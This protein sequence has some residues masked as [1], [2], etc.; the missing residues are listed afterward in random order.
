MATHEPEGVENLALDLSDEGQYTKAETLSLKDTR[1]DITND[2]FEDLEFD[3]NFV[4]EKIET[5]NKAVA[6]LIADH[7]VTLRQICYV[8]G[9]ILY[10]VFFFGAIYH[11]T[12]S[13][14]SD[15]QW[16]DGVGFLI[17]VTI[18]VYTIMFYFK[19]VKPS[20]SKFLKSKSGAKF[21]DGFVN[22]VQKAQEDLFRTR[23]AAPL[24][25]LGIFSLILI[26]LIIDTQGDRDRLKSF[27]GLIVL[28]LLGFFFS[29]SPG[30]V[31]WR[32]L[33]WGLSLQFIF[34]I[35]IIKWSV[36][37]SIFDCLGNKVS[38]LQGSSE[39]HE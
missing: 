29:K 28:V 8:I 9:F 10:N 36:G 13:D 21:Q 35:F 31:V 5:F 17:I 7:Q 25:Y 30:K 19:I 33:A 18:F 16:C 32:H 6:D 14:K 37:A 26:Y 34:A 4:T 38:K 11:F 20:Y 2:D 24:V 27:F 22:R 39:N 3:T 12:L 1:L 15:L 23:W